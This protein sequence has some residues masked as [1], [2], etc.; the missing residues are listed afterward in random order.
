[1]TTANPT[2]DDVL[3][4]IIAD[5]TIRDLL[6]WLG[7]DDSRMHDAGLRAPLLMIDAAL[8]GSSWER[9]PSTVAVIR[10]I[11]SAVQTSPRSTNMRLDDLLPRAGWIRNAASDADSAAFSIRAAERSRERVPQFAGVGAGAAAG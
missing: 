1:M 6:T 10:S 4:P 2:L 5:W 11:A 8:T 7:D 3:A 9:E